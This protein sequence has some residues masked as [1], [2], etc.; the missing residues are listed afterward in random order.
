MGPPAPSRGKCGSDE[1]T[2]WTNS[3]SPPNTPASFLPSAEPSCMSSCGPACSS[4]CA[5]APQTHPAAA[6]TTYVE[7]LRQDEAIDADSYHDQVVS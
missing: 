2:G 4:R 3:Y 7:Q 1:D 5:S 6:L